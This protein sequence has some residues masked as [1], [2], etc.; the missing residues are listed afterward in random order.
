MLISG[1]GELHLEII[2]DRLKREFK[3]E[4][5]LGQPQVLLMETPKGTG[6]DKA[7]FEREQD[8]DRLHG[9]VHI[10]VAPGERG[11]GVT[12]TSEADDDFLT[13]SLLEAIREG[14]VEGTK[15]GPSH[16]YPMDDVAI[17]LL[18]AGWKDTWSQPLGF[19]IAASIAVRNA[20]AKA[21]SS[22]LEPIMA[23]EITVP[24][25]HVGEIIGGINSR[26]GRI[27]DIE[28]RGEVK[29]V[30]AMVPLQQMFGYAT[31][32]RSL[33]QGRGVYAMRFSHYDN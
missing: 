15:A 8:S 32:L 31:E 22:V 20:C 26:R 29:V 17:T 16:S 4:V 11:K 5:R 19:K 21:G 7:V 13:D 12:F 9:E 3:I 30:N 10:R 18:G 33:T 2:A 25:E 6:E 28:D 1:M 14:A 27:E 24:D 23:T